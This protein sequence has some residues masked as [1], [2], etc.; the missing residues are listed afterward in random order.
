MTDAS[1]VRGRSATGGNVKV[2]REWLNEGIVC[3]FS[4]E[5]QTEAQ[6]DCSPSLTH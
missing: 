2:V 1:M 4:D 3:T 6:T 5:E